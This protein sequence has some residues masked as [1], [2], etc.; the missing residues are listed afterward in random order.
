MS[1]PMTDE[2]REFFEV[3]VAANISAIVA[4]GAKDKYDH[5]GIYCITVDKKIV[6]VGKS[7]NMLKRIAQHMYEIE[8][9]NKKNMYKVLKQLK[10]THQI[11]F[12]V[13]T[14][15]DEDDKQ[16]GRAEAYA[17]HHHN[18]CLNIQHPHLDDYMKYDYDKRAKNISAKEVEEILDNNI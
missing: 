7:R 12:D 16:L 5:Y 17:I 9:N 18:P 15:T 2:A 3:Q 8:Y 14:V 10:S 1:K 11:G 4:A 13:L 6:Y